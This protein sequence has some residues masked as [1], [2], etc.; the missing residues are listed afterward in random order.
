VAETDGRS[1]VQRLLV[2]VKSKEPIH[3]KDE[4]EEVKY[5][6]RPRFRFSDVLLTLYEVQVLDPCFLR[7]G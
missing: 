4:E 5:K 3:S 6:L 1:E 2:V 7:G